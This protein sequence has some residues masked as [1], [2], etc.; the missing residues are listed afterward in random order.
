[1]GNDLPKMAKVQSSNCPLILRA[2]NGCNLNNNNNTELTDDPYPQCQQENQAPGGTSTQ[3]NSKHK[4]PVQKGT[5]VNECGED[6]SPTKGTQAVVQQDWKLEVLAPNNNQNIP[7]P[8]KPAPDSVPSR[9]TVF[10]KW[11]AVERDSQRAL[12]KRQLSA[13]SAA[14]S[15]RV[16]KKGTLRKEE[17]EETVA[18][19]PTQS[20]PKVQ[21]GQRRGL[22]T[23]AIPKRKLRKE[24]V[25]SADVF[26]TLDAHAI[27]TGKQD[28]TPW[29]AS[30]VQQHPPH[31]GLLR[32]PGLF[33]FVLSRSVIRVFLNSLGPRAGFKEDLVTEGI[34]CVPVH[35]VFQLREQR[36]FSAQTI[37]QGITHTAKSDLERL[38]AIWV[39]LCDNIEYD[40]SG[41]LGQS[42]KLCSPE[43]VIEAGRGVCCGYSS[44]CLEM[45][46]T[47]GIECQEVSGHSKGIGYRQGQS[48]HDTKSNHMWNAVRLGG[49]W[50][51]MDAC[52]GSGRVDMDNK[53]F[54]KRYD[55]FYFLTD[56]EDFIDSHCPDD[57]QWQLLDAPIS[58]EEF[59]K[60]VFKTSEFYRLGLKLVH[61]T[62]YLMVTENGEAT[63]SIGF[64]KRTEF[65]YQI[66]Q[67]NVVDSKE[68][69]SSFGLLTV[70]SVG[71]KL[72]LLPPSQGRYEV[73]V[74]AR[75]ADSTGTFNWVCSFH[76]DCPEPKPSE[77]LPENPFLS[78]GLQ[79]SASD[80]GVSLS[81]HGS[82]PI[83]I[84]NGS[85]Q[86]E[87]QT[88]RP[89]MVLC[90][91]TH[92]D[93][94]AALS[95]RCLATQIKPDQLICHVLCPFRGF[96]RLSVF[97][98]DYD[99]AGD[100]FQNAGNF[101]LHCTANPINLNELFPP[102]LSSSC[103]PGIRT[104]SAGLS[105][106]SHQGALVSTQQGKCNITFHNS[107]DLE[108]HAVLTKERSEALG[109]SLARHILFTYTDC[110]VTV[111][112][113]LPEPGVYRL[114][115]Y[116]KT[117]PGQDFNPLCDFILRC[118]S[119]ASW[120]PF[121]CVYSAWRKGCVLFE[122]R[123]GWLQPQSWVRFRVR[124]PGAQSVSVVGGESRTPL[125][126]NKSRVWEGEVLAGSAA[127]QLKL[128]ASGRGECNEIAVIMAF[129]VVN[130]L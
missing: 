110:K 53:A 91:F 56:P 29:Q 33:S 34:C 18:P 6:S 118:P 96:Y 83:E 80:I 127:S 94:D 113:T 36:V 130:Q 63:V 50:Y 128:A 41:Y 62:H 79:P 47:L 51:L 55:D 88:S 20:R 26:K 44:L 70:T 1:M 116:G 85:F 74:F 109:Y 3:E 78:W 64:S 37:A 24:L 95:K 126:L 13:E 123:S 5:Q 111:S 105:K 71:M 23:P 112:V 102:S 69:G 15:F 16:V 117:T 31:L 27:T 115:L 67:L 84:Q 58:L 124:V 81:S 11:A 82:E 17:G 4:V 48:Y 92:K 108:L 121:P 10:E 25:S 66:S 28:E 103:G 73:I 46:R 35:A 101:L 12:A 22:K 99:Q 40:V 119:E 77:E 60:R 49:H 43:E 120:P 45:C 90:E 98:R 39:W 7:A 68:I 97:V 76:L 2:D 129:D 114:G 125:Q 122:P 19:V 30:G 65:T 75:P 107:R 61:P 8:S 87:L 21:A 59:E 57:P 32:A 9:R 54:I 52:W 100:R 72:R 42:E 14:C 93:M 89:L 38:R 106:F 104:E 86:L